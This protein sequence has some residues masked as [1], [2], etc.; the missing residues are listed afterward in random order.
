MRPAKKSD[1]QTHGKSILC[2]GKLPK[3][4]SSTSKT[5][6]QVMCFKQLLFSFVCG[7]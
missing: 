7:S 6:A 3:L 5:T 4:H 2:A 1:T